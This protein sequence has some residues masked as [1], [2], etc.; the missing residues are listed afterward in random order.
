MKNWTHKNWQPALWAGVGALCV[1]VSIFFVGLSVKLVRPSALGSSMRVIE[2]VSLHRNTSMELSIAS[3]TLGR[4]LKLLQARTNL[5]AIQPPSLIDFESRP[6][7][8]K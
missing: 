7:D 1:F 6:N 4:P 2:D 8:L 5:K 3:W